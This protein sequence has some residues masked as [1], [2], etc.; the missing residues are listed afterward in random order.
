MSGSAFDIETMLGQAAQGKLA[1]RAGIPGVAYPVVATHPAPDGSG[2]MTNL[3]DEDFHKFTGGIA[4]KPVPGA[5]PAQAPV[6]QQRAAP[7]DVENMLG[8]ASQG[9]LPPPPPRPKQMAQPY[10]S[11]AIPASNLA[12]G[13]VGGVLGLP[14]DIARGVTWLGGQEAAQ[15]L[16]GSP[17]PT[18]PAFHEDQG[19]SFKPGQVLPPQTLF[20]APGK[21]HIEPPSGHNPLDS[22]TLLGLTR[23]LGITNRPDL[24]PQNIGESI[25]AAANRGVGMMAPFIATG[26]TAAAPALIRTGALMGVGGEAGGALGERIGG[27]PGHVV[28]S[29]VGGV[30]APVGMAAATQGVRAAIPALQRAAPFTKGAR[31]SIVARDLAAKVTPEERALLASPP[32]QVPGSPKTSFQVTGNPDLG[33]MEKGI[34]NDPRYKAEFADIRTEQTKK[35]LAHIEKQQPPGADVGDIV[36]W[37]RGRLEELRNAEAAELSGER[38]ATQT[39]LDAAGN[40]LAPHEAGA[41]VRGAVEEARAPKIARLEGQ[42]A[43]ADRVAQER[44]AAQGGELPGPNTVQTEG[45]RMRGE[46]PSEEVPG[47]GVQ[48]ARGE[49]RAAADRMYAVV[50]PDKKLVVGGLNSVGDTASLLA[51]EAAPRKGWSLDDDRAR[52]LARF[53]AP[54]GGLGLQPSEIAVL[55]FAKTLRDA[56][57]FQ[58][59]RELESMAA[60]AQREFGGHRDF[61]RESLPYRRMTELR[62]ATDD[63]LA[64]AAGEAVAANPE[65]GT[66]LSLLAGEGLEAGRR[67]P[68]PP[69]TGAPDLFGTE[70][71]T[72]APREAEPT[73]RTDQRQAVMPGMEPSAT[74]AQA[75]RDA[76][77]RGGLVPEVP[78][79]PANEGLF[80]PPPV[81]QPTLPIGP[82]TARFLEASQPNFRDL[83]HEAPDAT[84]AS[85]AD[86]AF[87]QGHA[88]GHEHLALVDNATGEIVHAGTNGLPNKVNFRSETDLGAPDAFTFHHNH[89][90]NTAASGPDIAMLTNPGI[91]HIVAHGHD[92]S[93]T[94]VRLTPEFAN[95]RSPERLVQNQRA[96]LYAYDRAL[97]LSAHVLRPLMESGAITRDVANDLYN[98]VANRFMHAQGAIDYATTIELPAAVKTSVETALG[99]LGHAPETY[100]RYTGTI[101]PEERVAGLPAP[102]RERTGQGQPGNEAGAGPGAP[103]SAPGGQGNAS[104]GTIPEG[105]AGINGGEAGS[106]L[107]AGERVPDEHTVYTPTGR[108]I[109]VRYRVVDADSLVPSH[110]DELKVNPDYPAELQPRERERSA[111]QA[112]VQQIAGNLQPERLGPSSSTMEGAPIVGPGGVVESGNGRTLA[113]RRALAENGPQAEAYRAHLKQLGYDAGP[114]DILVGERTTAMTPEERIRFTQESNVSPGSSMSA[115]EKA[116]VDSK[117]MSDDL[118]GLWRSGDVRSAANR[119]FVRDFMR[120]VSDANERGTLQ[121]ADGSLSRDGEQRIKAALLDKAYGDARFVSAMAEAQ[122]ETIKPFGAAMS[123]AAGDMAR[124]KADIAAGQANPTTDISSNLLEAARLVSQARQK[125]ISIRDMVGQRDMLGGGIQPLTEQIL[126]EAYGDNLTGRISAAKFADKLTFYVDEARKQGGLFGTGATPEEILT[127]GVSR[128]GSEPS[129]RA[130]AAPTPPS[131]GAGFGAGAPEGGGEARRP[132]IGTTGEGNVVA[133]SVQ[134]EGQASRPVI[135]IV[136]GMPGAAQPALPGAARTTPPNPN[137]AQLP[138]PE[139]PTGNVVNINAG[140]GEARQPG[141]PGASPEPLV[142]NVTQADR[143]KLRAA[144]ANYAD[145]KDR[146]GSGAVGK[147]LAGDH[148]TVSGFKVEDSAVPATLFAPKGAG[149]EAADSLIRAM[150]SRDGALQVLGEYPAYSLR[151]A[152]ERMG[153]LSVPEYDKWVVKHAA[154]LDKFPELKSSFDT[155]AKAQAVLDDLH[156]QRAAIDAAHPLK[157]GWN[158]AQV[159]GNYAKPGPQGYERAAALIDE[160]GNSAQAREAVRD[161]L[162]SQL[163]ERA[164]VR[165][166]PNAGEI[167]PRLHAKFMKDYESFLSHPAMAGARAA[168]ENVGRAQETL[169]AVAVAHKEARDAY[170]KSVAKHFLPNAQGFDPDP[171]R[172]MTTILDSRNASQQIA[173]L[174]QQTARDPVAREAI[175]KAVIEAMLE[176]VKSTIPVGAD[177]EQAGVRANEVHKFIAKHVDGSEAS[178]RHTMEPE[179]L[180][181]L[182]DV[183]LDLRA[184]NRVVVGGKNV[185]GSPTGLIRS[186]HKAAEHQPSLMGM[187][188][189]IEGGGEVLHSL[190]GTKGRAVA[191]AGAFLLQVGRRVGYRSIRDIEADALLHPERMSALLAK[192]PTEA[193]AP[194]RLA[195]IRAQIAAV[196]AMQGVR[197]ANQNE[198]QPRRSTARGAEN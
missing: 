57:T 81:Q 94:V 172:A 13:F 93:T 82:R 177:L 100:D 166:G 186:A 62:R 158:D 151:Q 110:T 80:A 118:M 34:A 102:T 32:E 9:K 174:A 164:E 127:Q 130:K 18:A 197:A 85:A 55:D 161:Y 26:G 98:D 113:I 14:G 25:S 77:G 176:K 126:R 1:P 131:S 111:S 23:A 39:A 58:R 117:R 61:G 15:R 142:P 124:L 137:A 181:A 148:K 103:V 45:A 76:Q 133:G 101:R 122:D 95:Q 120:D 123:D 141:L 63:A 11:V 116:R 180:K 59:L 27:A 20:E 7:L 140:M 190:M 107:S 175:Q 99:R 3:S 41:A 163:R 78:Q 121:T 83:T 37:F 70:R 193:E 92:G 36:P 196:A 144:N 157:P 105:R 139:P 147:I 50:D 114:N 198:Q 182:R 49:A 170:L 192:V 160:T 48:G 51:G 156:A 53:A 2:A 66:Q 108:P 167:D 21:A 84:H 136:P 179:Q 168:F 16:Q 19:V 138:L 33:V 159:I 29:L 47:S 97:D 79:A 72:P 71:P 162:A 44:L 154:V 128:A 52:D 191:A 68:T 150:G 35:Q 178:L 88:T 91:S 106:T 134:P 8:L 65:V 119:D 74:Q 60:R 43:E 42:T 109:A 184:A 155:A 153:R 67:L 132:G 46:W 112:Q 17:F 6:E 149:A 40:P 12:E 115:S 31:E 183:G 104:G 96:I 28:G 64:K 187:L 4:P 129:L 145:Y 24:E 143:A 169:D 22:E 171:V 188:A 152:A 89:P 185:E 135:N 69:P 146:F 87:T 56:D 165:T 5:L 86:W 10:R 30:A 38:A 173:D 195:A 73:I 54:R 90:N 194:S 189:L 75:A 125:G